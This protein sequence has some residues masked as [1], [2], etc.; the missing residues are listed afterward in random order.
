MPRV[1]HSST[2]LRVT[3]V[4]LEVYEWNII[5]TDTYTFDVAKVELGHL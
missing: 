5:A 4:E 1:G 2:R 3:F